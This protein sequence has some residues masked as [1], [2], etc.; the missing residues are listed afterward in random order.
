MSLRPSPREY[1]QRGNI[2][3]TGPINEPV[4]LEDMRREV[5]ITTDE[6]D[7]TLR[8]LIVMAR[9]EIESKTG[10]AFINQIHE[11][12]FDNW[13]GR[14]LPQYSHAD[15]ELPYSQA[16]MD[17]HNFW[18]ELPRYPL[19]SVD[20]VTVYDEASN[21]TAVVIA[22]T[23]D[24]DTQ[25]HL[26]GR[27][28][29]QSGAAWPVALRSINSIVVR[30]TAGFGT[31]QA[32]VPFPLRRA[33]RTMARHLFDNRDCSAGNAFVASGAQDALEAYR[34]PRL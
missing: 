1:H 8:E 16:Y 4:E 12:T 23:F 18:V 17:H 2:L 10:L 13:P 15:G 26:R 28:A 5:R 25:T 11:V 9:E 19:V 24:V 34:M 21:A 6:H 7:E 20:T 31:L 29:L 22:D 30:Y 3:I 14:R 32:N 27:L 33:I